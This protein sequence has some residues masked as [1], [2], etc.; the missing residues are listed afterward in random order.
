MLAVHIDALDT[1]YLVRWAD[2]LGI[3]EDL[4]AALRET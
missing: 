3:G 4:K 1:G 2:E